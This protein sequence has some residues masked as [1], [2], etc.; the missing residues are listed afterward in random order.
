MSKFDVIAFDA[1]DTLWQNEHLYAEAQAGL[2]DL[3]ANYQPSEWIQER[4]YQTEMHNLEHFGYG[5]KAFALS[6][7]ETAI[8]L[9]D[10]RISGKDLQT[11]VNTAKDMLHADVD[12]LDNVVETLTQ[13]GEKYPLMLL[14]KGDLFEQENKI[15]RSGLR[16]RFHHIEILS[17]KSV[18]VYKE[19][20][21]RHS[22]QPER[23]LMVGNSLRSDILPI[24]E[25]GADAVYIPNKLTWQHEHADSPPDGKSGYHQLEHIGLLP[26]LIEGLESVEKE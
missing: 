13:L 18:P 3:L 4:L 19:L 24:L 16:D 8:E 9:T 25:L 1:D 7:V 21:E 17:K 2:V 6:M 22:I 14:T 23:F 5:I 11:L 26:A 15:A 10:G 20:F 12:V